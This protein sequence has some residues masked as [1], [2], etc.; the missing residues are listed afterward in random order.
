[1]PTSLKSY[2][3]FLGTA[4]LS[5][6]LT[7]CG[8]GGDSNT[9]TPIDTT[10]ASCF[11]SALFTKSNSVVQKYVLSGSNGSED[12]YKVS[13]SFSDTAA[14]FNGHAGLV[15]LT[16]SGQPE[17]IRPMAIGFYSHTYYLS[18]IATNE[19]VTYG[20]ES[21]FNGAQLR[22]Q[23]HTVYTPP[24]ADKKYTLREGE[25]TQ[26]LR[27]GQSTY[28]SYMRPEEVISEINSK[29]DVT[30]I[31]QEKIAIGTRSI[32]ACKFKF[33]TDDG[34]ET[35]NWFYKGIEVQKAQTNN[36][37]VKRTSELTLNNQPY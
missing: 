11:D 29:T 30:F 28:S 24:S 33:K 9:S 23:S 25:T 32:V 21:V 2:S 27:Q 15:T 10:A 35:L 12:A 19:V 1:M 26:I 3:L 5:A 13:W 4:F 6:T 34:G 20:I 8:G 37:L 18:P 16:E 36:Q 22:A 31:E 7:A 17:G 14:S